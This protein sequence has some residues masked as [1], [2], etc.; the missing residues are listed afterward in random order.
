MEPYEKILQ[1]VDILALFIAGLSGLSAAREA[2][3]DWV[4]AYVSAL[5]CGIGGGTLRDLLIGRTPVFWLNQPWV[6]AIPLLVILIG[7]S[8][9]RGHYQNRRFFLVADAFA[10]ALFT[11]IGTRIALA[12]EILWSAPLLGAITG[13]AG[14]VMRDL[15][16]GRV[17]VVM[18]SEFYV[19]AA[20]LGAILQLILYHL[21][22]QEIITLLAVIFLIILLRLLAI[23]YHWRLPLV[24]TRE[25]T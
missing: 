1:I 8:F 13:T 14:G 2:R 22:T 7:E 10:L 11:W 4:G 20:L 25:I 17:P 19:S 9:L 12:H 15:I 5:L 6:L 18:R 21:K 23:R 16:C 3:L 24:G